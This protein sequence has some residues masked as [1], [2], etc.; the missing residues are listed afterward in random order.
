MHC[1][2]VGGAGILRPAALALLREGHAVTATARTHASLDSL[3]RAAAGCPGEVYGIAGDYDRPG[4][5]ALA[6]ASA[7]AA[8]GAFDL[9]LVY[10]PGPAPLARAA[11]AAHAPA[12]IV[13]ILTSGHGAPGVGESD[14]RRTAAGGR[15]RSVR[16]LLGWV[17]DAH[18]TRWHTPEEVSAAALSASHAADG[19]ELVLGVLRPWRDR[20]A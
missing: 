11:L 8:R 10:T 13:D 19:S 2:V 4:A 7:V 15:E 17:A 9:A 20:P 5:L 18:V 1:L 12:V 6:L 14:R 16:L 3:V